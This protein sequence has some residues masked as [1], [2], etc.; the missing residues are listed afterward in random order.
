MLGC[1]EPRLS[2][3]P[4][5]STTTGDEAIELAAIAGLDLDPWQQWCLRHSLGEQPDGRW[6]AFGVGVVVPRQNGKGGLL[7]ARELAGLFLLNE[8]L[9]IHS[10]HEFA[11]SQ[12]AFE[13]FVGLI[14]DTPQLS[15]RLPKKGI[16]R[17]HGSEGVRLKTGQRVRFRTRT[18]GGGRGFTCDCLIL[19]EAMILP[20]A[21]MSAVLPTLAARPNPQV[22]YTGSAVDEEI[23]EHGLVLARVRERG[24]KGEDPSLFY[25]EWSAADTLEEVTAERADDPEWWA[26]ANPALGIR[27]TTDYVTN[28]RREFDSNLRGFAVE[29][30]GVG[31]WPA[32][33]DSARRTI[34]PE[35]WEACLD[36]SSVIGNPVCIAFDVKPDRSWATISA[37]GR[38]ED[39]A[40]HT[41]IIQRQHGT[42]WI[43][44]RLEELVKKHRPVAVVCDSLSPAA[45][46]LPALDLLGIE[47]V[48]TGSR[49]YAAACGMYLDALVEQRLFH[50][51]TPELNQAVQGAS[52]RSLGGS[53]VWDRK[54]SAADITPLVSST[55][56]YWGLS[57]QDGSAPEVW[58]L[59]EIVAELKAEEGAE[60][61]AELT[62]EAPQPTFTPPP[63]I[64]KA[65][66]VTFIS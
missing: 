53:W 59:N 4:A 49:E 51:G 29:R 13:R 25:A 36:P 42:G 2:S 63:G 56:A 17:S 50:I 22:W 23:H 47:V 55:L 61:P 14:E 27:V 48:L 37:V 60:T 1:Q 19:D 40:A 24:L 43:A 30:L 8:R 5:Y 9:I 62:P 54:G 34:T 57:T 31:A 38:R 21:F 12:E 16:S 39:G 32:T 7:E 44:K 64:P 33:D 46:L 58:D 10:A 15:R 18:K 65:P 11:T 45:S 52:T 6:S 26:R 20:D 3:V 28:E 41:E 66:P 35:V